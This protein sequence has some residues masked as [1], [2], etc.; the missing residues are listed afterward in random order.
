MMNHAE[1]GIH[2]R[3]IMTRQHVR[4][5]KPTFEGCL[6]PTAC[7]MCR[8]ICNACISYI[9]IRTITK[10]VMPL[11]QTNGRASSSRTSWGWRG[12]G[13]HF[14][15]GMTHS[16]SYHSKLLYTLTP[17]LSSRECYV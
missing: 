5:K 10:E 6:H 9:H 14:A 7:I 2:T 12:C 16:Y 11:P 4:I 15:L 1:R 13:E 8:C 17:Y 3:N